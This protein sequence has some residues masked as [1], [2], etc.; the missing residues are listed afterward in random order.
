MGAGSDPLGALGT[1]SRASIVRIL[2]VV[3]VASALVFGSQR[4]LPWLA[5]KL[6]GRR[7]LFILATVP[8]LRLVIISSATLLIF[9]RVI[10][11]S[12]EN[13]IAL[14]GAA[15]LALGFA[16]KDYVSSLIAGVVAVY[17]APYR[18]GD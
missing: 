4:L 17:E 6:S 12:I 5:S 8:A 10:E 18:P 11:P 1:I 2:L 7:R 13:V 15:G 14:L 9:A 16:F 3:A